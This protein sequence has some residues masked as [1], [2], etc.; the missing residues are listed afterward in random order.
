MKAWHRGHHSWLL[1]M[2]LHSSGQCAAFAGL[3]S[4]DRPGGV[5]VTDRRPTDNRFAVGGSIPSRIAGSSTTAASAAIG[6][7]LRLSHEEEQLGWASS[8]FNGGFAFNSFHLDPSAFTEYQRRGATGIDS[9][10]T[11]TLA[12]K[13]EVQPK[14]GQGP[15]AE[16]RPRIL[17]PPRLNVGVIA[18]TASC[19]G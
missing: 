3:P 12:I 18:P 11:N 19:T 13:P 14:S 8:F 10:A 6:F 17:G 15:S 1:N 9:E 16:P 5:V 7:E 4:T 2:W